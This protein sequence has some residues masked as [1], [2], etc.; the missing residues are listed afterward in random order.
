[1]KNKYHNKVQPLIKEIEV[2]ER[3]L[4]KCTKLN[5]DT[6]RIMR[7]IEL[8][9]DKIAQI[10]EYSKMQNSNKK[11]S[12]YSDN[13]LKKF[14]AAGQSADRELD[15]AGIAM[16]D[17]VMFA[18]KFDKATGS[19]TYKKV[20]QL[21]DAFH[22]GHS[23]HT[24]AYVKVFE[25]FRD[26]KFSKDVDI[27]EVEARMNDVGL[28]EAQRNLDT[29]IKSTASLP[30]DEIL[31][32]LDKKAV[33][34]FK[35]TQKLAKELKKDL[36][37]A[38]S[39]AVK[40]S[41]PEFDLGK[42]EKA[43]GEM[44]RATNKLN[45]LVN[46]FGSKIKKP[47][48]DLKRILDNFSDAIE[49]EF[50][51]LEDEEYDYQNSK[52]KNDMKRWDS[53]L[54]QADRAGRAISQEALSLEP[55]AKSKAQKEIGKYY[56]ALESLGR[57]VH[58]SY[59]NSKG[60]TMKVNNDKKFE[61]LS[62]KAADTAMKI[63]RTIDNVLYSEKSFEDRRLWGHWRSIRNNCSG[64]DTRLKM[65]VDGVERGNYPSAHKFKND[66]DASDSKTSLALIKKVEPM[67]KKLDSQVK[68]HL[69]YAKEQKYDLAFDGDL[70]RDVD[71]IK[72]TLR[73]T[74]QL[75]KTKN[76]KGKPM[77]KVR[78][79]QRD[80][81]TIVHANYLSRQEWKRMRDAAGKCKSLNIRPEL[82]KLDQSYDKIREKCEDY[83]W[84]IESDQIENSKEKSN[85]IQF[86]ATAY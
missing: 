67:V 7:E 59:D 29:I 62:K 37:E 83:I 11:L 81:N 12:K 18:R 68:E 30:N 50:R 25:E 64:V 63:L 80:A 20:K 13:D 3:E 82:Q 26:R 77:K 19:N 55:K 72:K 49:T 60:K 57:I 52:I 33:S 5:W 48:R 23:G 41:K 40:N 34:A 73:D 39:K 56:R 65:N 16:F 53:L 75:S 71:S 31:K 86:K 51:N 21:E 28:K 1:M 38:A 69:K 84:K 10:A 46:N 17:L 61:T 2:L 4:R 70:K 66:V 58:D 54:T 85:V 35:K 79:G 8:N 47:Y 78:N 24:L 45:P 74:K 44:I 22:V 36:T 76:S 15:K 32:L 6:R 43:V 14:Y 27:A 9:L 42:I